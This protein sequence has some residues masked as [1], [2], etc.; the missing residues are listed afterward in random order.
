VISCE[1]APSDL[2]KAFR[3]LNSATAGVQVQEIPARKRLDKLKDGVTVEGVR[4][5][6]IEAILDKAK[7]G[8]SGSNLWIT[9][10]LAEGKNREVRRVLESLGLKV[11]R[12][13]RLSYGPY[14]LAT[15]PVGAVEE[16]GPR[17]IREQLAA[18][19]DPENM[20]TSDK[21][22]WRSAP[23]PAGS[24]RRVGPGA[25]TV[26]LRDPSLPVVP[27]KKEYKA[28]WAKAKPK[29]GHP[30]KSRP[31][32]PGPAVIGR[33]RTGEGAK[34]PESA[35]PSTPKPGDRPASAASTKGAPARRPGPPPK[36]G[37]KRR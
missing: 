15:L 1:I 20:P 11:N 24:Q 25:K 30:T 14:A 21:T 2:A 10:T 22:Q 31:S 18:Y 36:G 28:G 3:A 26:S 12:L 27:V 8:P 37:P 23:L 9:L 16:V 6:A 32:K 34:G 13:I 5:G 29:T 7:D 4:Y 19:I 35:R 17:V 33:N